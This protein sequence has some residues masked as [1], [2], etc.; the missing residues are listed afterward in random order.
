MIW[1]MYKIDTL[2]VHYFVSKS[3]FT[4]DLDD[5]LMYLS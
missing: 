5:D 2:F 3:N 1:Y 4:L